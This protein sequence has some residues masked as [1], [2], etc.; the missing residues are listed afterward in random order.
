MIIRVSVNKCD[1]SALIMCDK[2]Y[3]IKGHAGHRIGKNYKRLN[4]ATA[5]CFCSSIIF[6]VISGC[7]CITEKKCLYSYLITKHN[8]LHDN[9]SRSFNLP[10]VFI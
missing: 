9:L 7:Q 1:K 8:K 5:K 2:F 6:M 3:H 4:R 10:L